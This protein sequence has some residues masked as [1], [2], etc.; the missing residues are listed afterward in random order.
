MSI[1]HQTKPKTLVSSRRAVEDSQ[2]TLPGE[3]QYRGDDGDDCVKSSL[4]LTGTQ[5]SAG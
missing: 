1:L 4:N 5:T 2:I 3:S